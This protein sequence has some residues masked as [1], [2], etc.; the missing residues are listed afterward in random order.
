VDA[1]RL[2]DAVNAPV[3]LA[4]TILQTRKPGTLVSG[5]CL[6]V[7]GIWFLVVSRWVLAFGLWL[8]ADA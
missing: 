3:H 1:P 5:F 2:G 7:I 4:E 6:L 8:L